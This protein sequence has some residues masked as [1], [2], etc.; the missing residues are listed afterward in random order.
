M[1]N[2]EYGRDPEELFEV[3]LGRPPVD[4]PCMRAEVSGLR[5]EGLGVRVQ[6]L[7]VRVEG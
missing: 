4:P 2:M 5:V 7:G 3:L 6:S 1:Y